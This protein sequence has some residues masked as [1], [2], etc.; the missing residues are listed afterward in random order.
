MLRHV[1][2]ADPEVSEEHTA[3]IFRI[4]LGSI[5]DPEGG[6]VPPKRRAPSEL[7]G[8]T[9]AFFHVLLNSL[10]NCPIILHYIIWAIEGVVK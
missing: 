3:P 8:V 5:F 7:Q 9:T 1:V 2:W 6:S 4:L 10:L